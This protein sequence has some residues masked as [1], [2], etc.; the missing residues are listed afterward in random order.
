M[1]E[2]IGVVAGVIALADAALEVGKELSTFIQNF[3]NAPREVVALANE[4]DELTALL[5][6]IRDTRDQ[7]SSCESI[8]LNAAGLSS[9]RA[10]IQMCETELIILRSLVQPLYGNPYVDLNGIR[11]LKWIF[12][13]K[14]KIIKSQAKLSG[15]K[16]TLTVSISTH[17]LYADP[18]APLKTM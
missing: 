15:L 11:R 5:Q 16:L 9:L 1:A 8:T 6:Q 2:A 10:T 7:L 18:N 4:L 13:V 12:S 3:R 17:G 14:N